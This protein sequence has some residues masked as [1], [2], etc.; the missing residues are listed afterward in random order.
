MQVFESIDRTTMLRVRGLCPDRIKDEIQ[1]LS[2]RPPKADS[3]GS[4]RQ[5]LPLPRP[6]FAERP[7]LTRPTRETKVKQLGPQVAEFCSLSFD[8]VDPSAQMA[9]TSRMLV[10]LQSLYSGRVVYWEDTERHFEQAFKLLSLDDAHMLKIGGT[11]QKARGLIESNNYRSAYGELCTAR[12]YLEMWSANHRSSDMS[13]Q[14]ASTEMP[15]PMTCEMRAPETPSTADPEQPACAEGSLSSPRHQKSHL[16][17]RQ[18]VLLSAALLELRRVCLQARPSQIWDSDAKEAAGQEHA[19]HRKRHGD[20]GDEVDVG[21]ACNAR[22][23]GSVAVE[24]CVCDASPKVVEE[25]LEAETA[26]SADHC[27]Y[28]F[29][30]SMAKLKNADTRI[31]KKTVLPSGEFTFTFYPK[32]ASQ[33]KGGSSFKAS[34]G[35]CTAQIKFIS[36]LAREVLITVALGGNP[37]KVQVRHDFSKDSACVIPDV[38]DLRKAVDESARNFFV[39][40]GIKALR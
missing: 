30:E 10:F 2:V 7:R 32:R 38:L 40:F 17:F 25:G 35:H 12:P 4:W 6:S 34:K 1:H 16:F 22:D 37:P 14:F 21:D 36:G 19:S 26:D 18:R 9:L 39:V 23:V 29:V 33:K 11:I 8:G 13:G 31:T 28:A 5:Q 24:D 15:N 27:Q 20:T 3:D